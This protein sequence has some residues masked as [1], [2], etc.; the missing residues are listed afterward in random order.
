MAGHQM[1]RAGTWETQ[2]APF[3]GGVDTDNVESGGGNE[4]VVGVGLTHSRGVVGAMPGDSPRGR[5]RKVEGLEGVSSQLQTERDT[6]STDR[7]GEAVITKLSVITKMARGHPRCK[8]TN[9]AY[10]LN[11]GY[12]ARCF[13]ELRREV[14][15]GIDG[16]TYG[17]YRENLWENLRVLVSRLKTRQY[18]PQP[19]RRVWIPKD[20][21]SKRPLGIPA[22]EDKM[23]QLG[24][25]KI[26]GAIFEGDFLDGSYGFRP[27]RGCHQ[28]LD[29]LDKGIMTKPVNFVLDADIKG[30]FDSVD[31]EK[32]M[33]CLRQ[34]ITDSS[35]LRLVVRFLKA[36]VMEEGQYSRAERGT[37]QGGILSPML[38]NI[39]LH[40]VLDRWI[41]RKLKK[42]LRGYAEVNRYADDFVICVQHKDE[43]ERILAAVEERFAQVGLS[44]SKE[45]TRLIEFGRY[46]ADRAARRGEK[47]ATFDYLGFTHYCDKTR[48]EK[49]KVG[50]KT[51]RK[52]YRRKLEAMNQWLKMIR[53]RVPL[54]EWWRLLAAKLEGHYR[55]YGVSGNA[56]GIRRYHEAVRRLA[57]KW[58]NRRSQRKGYDWARFCEYLERYPLPQP[59]IHHHMYTLAPTR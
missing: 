1:E 54:K 16:V 28:A 36:G 23:V 32:L 46:A 8:F 53:N 17:K 6:P 10:L 33:A 56:E 11:E 7:S 37:P 12:L 14:A 38:S 31:H 51:A 55:Y 25:T 21:K 2:H 3:R 29:A 19:V 34:R 20:E 41:E 57:Y 58:I 40:Y 43:A 27:G 45:K 15:P 24:M 39:F 42:E 9:L 5:S 18:R 30:F 4:G 44:L 13:E 35:F 22:L 52:K 50:R 49:F 59:R 47:P 48:R 26:M